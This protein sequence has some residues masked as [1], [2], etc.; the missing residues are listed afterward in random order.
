MAYKTDFKN[1]VL[2]T[3]VNTQRTYNIVD[4]DGNVIFENVSFIDTTAYLVVGDSFGAS[5]ANALNEGVKT[6]TEALDNGKVRFKVDDDGEVLVS[7]Y[8]EEA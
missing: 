6:V 1:D 8:T 7:T 3:D 5:E 2:N 4:K